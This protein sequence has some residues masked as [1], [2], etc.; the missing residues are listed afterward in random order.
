MP[1]TVERQVAYKV[2]LASLHSSEYVKQE[3][4]DPNYV[5]LGGKQVSRVHVVATVVSKFVADDGNY[6]ALT[7]DDGSETIRVKAFGPDV[8]RVENAKVGEL[9]RFVGKVKEY[10]EEV[11]L[12]PEIVKPLNSPNWLIA[13]Q[14]EL[15][16]MPARESTDTSSTKQESLATDAIKEEKTVVD[17]SVNTKILA[18]IKELDIGD[19]AASDD[20]VKNLGVSLEEAKPKIAEL[21]ASGEIYEPKKGMLK[22]L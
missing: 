6:G 18:L 20:V 1:A 8:K 14:L 16:E 9:V 2:W 17:E 22:L 21:L 13:H 3:G 4:W 19:G 12:S 15:G 5:V 10:N 7:I 11:Y